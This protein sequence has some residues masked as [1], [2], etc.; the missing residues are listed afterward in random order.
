[1]KIAMFGNYQVG[2]IS[3]CLRAM[4]PNCEVFATKLY[5]HPKLDDTIE[6]AKNCDVLFTRHTFVNCLLKA[7]YWIVL[8]ISIS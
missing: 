2:G 8:K 7:E 5:L 6:V 1:M 4:A 3:Q